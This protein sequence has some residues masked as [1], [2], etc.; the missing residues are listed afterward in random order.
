M[1]PIETIFEWMCPI[2]HRIFRKSDRMELEEFKK[3][4]LRTHRHEAEKWENRESESS[5]K[6][7]KI[8]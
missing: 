1:M 5:D 2:C 8:M 6:I 3:L 7:K 4:H